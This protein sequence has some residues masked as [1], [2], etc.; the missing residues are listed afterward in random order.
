MKTEF[1]IES[2]ETKKC[3]HCLRRTDI[4]QNKCSYCRREDFIYDGVFISRVI[5]P[6]SSLFKS[7]GAFFKRA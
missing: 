2:I 7:I 1:E 5:P 3:K 4:E 6:K